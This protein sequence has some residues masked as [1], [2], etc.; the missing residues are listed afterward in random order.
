MSLKMNDVFILDASRVD[1]IGESAGEFLTLFKAEKSL[2]LKVKLTV[3]DLLLGVLDNSSEPRN[4]RLRFH[5]RLS[6][7]I[8]LVWS[9]AT[10]RKTSERRYPTVYSSLSGTLFSV[11]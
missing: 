6:N 8:I 11:Y 2:M 1:Q 9:A 5:K 3:E 7:G 4:C 10:V